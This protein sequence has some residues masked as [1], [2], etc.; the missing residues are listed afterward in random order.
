MTYFKFSSR[1]AQAFQAFNKNHK[2]FCS[3]AHPIYRFKKTMEFFHHAEHKIYMS[4]SC[5]CDHGSVFM[6]FDGVDPKK[7]NL[8]KLDELLLGSKR[9]CAGDCKRIEE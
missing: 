2:L 1:M 8:S 9:R 5:L 3:F 4:V 7:E 6:T